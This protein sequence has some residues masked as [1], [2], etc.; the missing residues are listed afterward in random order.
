MGN[1]KSIIYKSCDVFQRALLFSTL[2]FLVWMKLYVFQKKFLDVNSIFFPNP[3]FTAI[4]F[5]AL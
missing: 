3:R 1:G 5:P 2:S 4:F